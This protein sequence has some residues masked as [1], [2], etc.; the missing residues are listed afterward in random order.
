M[1]AWKGIVAVAA[2]IAIVIGMGVLI[3]RWRATDA[4]IAAL[5]AEIA[6]LNKGLAANSAEVKRL[7]AAEEAD[8]EDAR[9][10]REALLTRIEHIQVVVPQQAQAM[11][12]TEAVGE[13]RRLINDDGVSQVETGVMFTTAAFRFNLAKLMEGEQFSLALRESMSESKSLAAALAAADA[14]V[15][16]HEDS[17]FKKDEHIKKLNIELGLAKKSDTMKIVKGVGVGVAAGIILTLLLHR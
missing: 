7:S 1:K 10:W 13:T 2:I 14:K 16:V 9:K 5:H 6:E 15:V 17:L 12:M 11:P 3:D 4:T 8:K